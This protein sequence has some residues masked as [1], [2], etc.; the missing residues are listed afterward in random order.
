MKGWIDRFFKTR[1]K[2][3]DDAKSRLKLLLIH[4]QVDLTP[5]QMEA[6][7]NEIIGVISRYV[8]I[9]DDNVEFKLNKEEDGVALVSNIPVRRV[10]ARAAG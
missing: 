1:P 5:A 9:D 8:E 3:K 10:T 6:M 7:K 4:D 2:S